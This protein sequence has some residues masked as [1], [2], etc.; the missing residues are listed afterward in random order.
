QTFHNQLFAFFF[1]KKKR[2]TLIRQHKSIYI[3]IP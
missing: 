3:N 2:K 1:F